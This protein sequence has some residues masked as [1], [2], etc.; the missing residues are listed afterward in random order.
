[1]S[2]FNSPI[3]KCKMA[4]QC[5]YDILSLSLCVCVLNASRGGG[6]G[7]RF[8]GGFDHFG[9]SCDVMSCRSLSEVVCFS[10]CVSL[11]RYEFVWEC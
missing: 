9:K 1:M 3:L 7:R 4:A 10:L 8:K 11:S 5:H 2:K 6:V